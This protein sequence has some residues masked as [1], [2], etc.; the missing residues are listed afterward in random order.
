MPLVV[1]HQITIADDE[2]EFRYDRS[3]G[4][5]G[6]NV[7]KLNT[8]AT[9]H[10]DLLNSSSIS[11]HVRDRLLNRY[12]NRINR[13]GR[14][15]IASQK[16]REQS[17]NADDCLAK[18]REFILEAAKPVRRRKK[19]RPTRASNQRRLEAKRRNS[20]KKRR[21]RQPPD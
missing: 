14:F 15:V 10:W 19:T 6:Q 20:E 3:S 11:E 18:L 5:G 12:A 1:N 9:L 4:P 13:E 2:L 8:K 21:R 17:R 16:H 7:N